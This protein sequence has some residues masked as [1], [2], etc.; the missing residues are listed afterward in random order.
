MGK[1]VTATSMKM[2]IVLRTVQNAGWY[3]S[4]MGNPITAGEASPINTD[5]RRDCPYTR[6][7]TLERDH[8]KSNQCPDSIAT[9]SS[10]DV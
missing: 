4:A 10:F 1:A 8:K 9:H 2:S 3:L 6:R 7:F 5:T